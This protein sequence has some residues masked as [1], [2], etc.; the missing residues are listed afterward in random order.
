MSGSMTRVEPRARITARSMTFSSSRTLPGHRYSIR[1]A[2]H[3]KTSAATCLS[4]PRSLKSTSLPIA[5]FRS[6]TEIRLTRDEPARD[7]GP[8]W[9]F[10]VRFWSKLR[11]HFVVSAP[12]TSFAAARPPWLLLILA[13]RIMR[14]V[15][16][17]KVEG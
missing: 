10:L 8:A 11:R 17:T 7:A 1:L 16:T 5:G 3:E 14:S 4:V 9:A 12:S 13:K 6:A 15:S 2:A